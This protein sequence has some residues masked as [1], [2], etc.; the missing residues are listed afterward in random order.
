MYLAND[1]LQNAVGFLVMYL[2]NDVLQNAV[3]L[4]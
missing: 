1:V 2:A 3:G 4:M